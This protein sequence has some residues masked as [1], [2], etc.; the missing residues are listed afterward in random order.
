MKSFGVDVFGIIVGMCECEGLSNGIEVCNGSSRCVTI[1]VKSAARVSAEV[2][3]SGAG[4]DLGGGVAGGYKL[5][6]SSIVVGKILVEVR[7]WGRMV[8]SV[9]SVTGFSCRRSG[10]SL[11]GSR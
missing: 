9:G 2:G 6:V 11:K 10:I 8:M 7:N 1:W 5:T 3:P 4:F